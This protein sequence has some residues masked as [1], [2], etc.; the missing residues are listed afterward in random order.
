MVAWFFFSDSDG[1]FQPIIVIG[2]CSSYNNNLLSPMTEF[3]RMQLFT[4][5]YGLPFTSFFVFNNVANFFSLILTVFFQ[6]SRKLRFGNNS[7]K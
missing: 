1:I 5:I 3:E 4:T 7:F 2:L 6:F